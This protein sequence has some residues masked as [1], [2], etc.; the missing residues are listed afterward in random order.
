M[1]DIYT[2]PAAR[3][4]EA[5][6]RI[7][8]MAE[9][10]GTSITVMP[11]GGFTGD[12]DIDMV[13]VM[14]ICTE[15]EFEGHRFLG[16]IDHSLSEAIVRMVPNAE[17]EINHFDHINTQQ[18]DHCQLNRRRNNTYLIQNTE[19]MQ[20]MQV[21]SSC[22]KEIF[23]T[24][25]AVIMKSVSQMV[26][27]RDNV[28]NYDYD[29]KIN[30][31]LHIDTKY[32]LQAVAEVLLTKPF[33]RTTDEWSTPT[34]DE[35]FLA[36]GNAVSQQAKDDAEQ[37]L[38]WAKSVDASKSDYLRT[39]YI[40]ANSEYITG[41]HLGYAASIISSWKKAM[42]VVPK[43]TTLGD[44]ATMIALFETA[45][46]RIKYPKVTVTKGDTTVVLARTGSGSKNPGC[47]SVCSEGGYGNNVFYGT[48][49]NDG[50]FQATRMSTDAVQNLLV[51]FAADPAGVAAAHGKHT[52]N[53]SFCNKKL[54]DKRSVHV[55]YGK[56]CAD[57][58]ELP[59]GSDGK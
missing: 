15:L 58:Y 8:N 25:P 24:D 3:V 44:F 32:Y 35:A 39:L 1:Y 23:T 28:I 50:T 45:S 30:E 57:H 36:Y 2:L 53:C 9:R 19:T 18:C 55:G 42:T 59:W 6:A 41:K 17:H 37:A 12:D 47:I 16:V 38:A 52:G 11:V 14:L 54:K 43:A 7:A 46:S 10:A 4:H 20:Y 21:G 22:L 27:V 49:R 5:K 34:R 40:I 26:A 33:V 48:I 29:Q 56:I 31:A 13:E 51:E